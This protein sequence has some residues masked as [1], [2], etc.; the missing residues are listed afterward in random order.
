MEI[1]E[2]IKLKE[3]YDEAMKKGEKEVAQTTAIM[4]VEK[5]VPDLL[6]ML[7]NEKFA[8][9]R[10]KSILKR[11][12]SE[13]VLFEHLFLE[14]QQK[15]SDL[16]GEPA[17]VGNKRR[18]YGE[19][20]NLEE[21]L[22]E[23]KNIQIITASLWNQRVKRIED[24][25]KGI[26]TKWKDSSVDSSEFLALLEGYEHNDWILFSYK[27]QRTVGDT[28]FTFN[29]KVSVIPYEIKE[30]RLDFRYNFYS[31]VEFKK[32]GEDVVRYKEIDGVSIED[33][34]ELLEGLNWHLNE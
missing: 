5:G 25:W 7:E 26:Y 14:E 15:V 32:D 30:G 34:E 8:V 6:K 16:K 18:I 4:L 11:K 24:M 23:G 20:F 17:L 1:Q 31:Y 27:G 21:L 19:Y 2:I 22:F 12:K 13:V 28:Q 29:G 3:T 9:K 10:T 33:K